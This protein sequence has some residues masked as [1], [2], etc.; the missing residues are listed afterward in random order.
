M[1]NFR[2]LVVTVF[3]L[4]ISGCGYNGAVSDEAGISTAWS[5]SMNV[6][7]AMVKEV[8]DAMFIAETDRESLSDAIT[9]YMTA[10]NP[11]DGRGQMMQ[12]TQNAGVDISGENFA[13]VIDIM[14]AKRNE[15]Q[16]ANT[17][18]IDRQRTYQISLDSIP[19]GFVLGMLGFPKP[20]PGCGF[21]AD[22]TASAPDPYCPP[23][24]KD[25]DGV[26][27][28]LDFP[29]IVSGSTSAVFASGNDNWT[30][31]G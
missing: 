26:A 13:R 17:S 1:V 21:N 24:D 27:T 14:E 9:G 11:V 25:R 8:S 29:V 16:N 31:G 15:F 19:N 23:V 30:L 3:A 4:G 28:V 5:Q 6:N 22:Y 7:D 10:Q 18:L 2:I 12:W 20:L